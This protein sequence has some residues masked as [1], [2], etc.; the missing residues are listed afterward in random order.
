MAPRVAIIVLNWNNPSDTLAGLESLTRLDYSE[1]TIL[2]VDN[3]S[4][5]DSV[6]Q[7]SACFPGIEILQTGVNLGYAEGNNVGIRHAL[8][9]N[10]EYVML[11][12]NDVVVAP[13]TLS[14]L[15][16]VA[17]QEPLAG[18]LGPKVYH[19]E[20]PQCLQS[21]GILLD[22]RYNSQHRGQ[23]QVDVGQF[24]SVKE[25]DAV[26]G[27]AMLTSRHVLERVGLL[28]SQF[29]IYHEEID[30]CLRARAA[31]FKNLYVPTAKVW[32]RK[33]QL[34]S[35]TTAFTTYYM[36]R[37]KYLLLSKQRAGVRALALTT[38]QNLTWLLNWTFNPK[39]RGHRE[40]RDALFKALIDAAL[41]NYGQQR[42]RYGR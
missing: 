39:W 27:C 24:E 4:T 30:W 41:G 14:K 31:G 23:D 7:I 11:L 20:E 25:V 34:R 22:R 8:E 9:Q 28:D 13:D 40:K 42:Y 10:A 2:V 32:H 17:G 21:A 29:F 33:P 26:S 36:T 12:N 35:A 38:M 18:F 5:D 1:Y 19:R 15:V 6:A 16:G 3:G 37:N